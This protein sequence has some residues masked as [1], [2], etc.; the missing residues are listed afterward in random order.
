MILH[1]NLEKIGSL[2]SSINITVKIIS[3]VS[4]PRAVPHPDGRGPGRGAGGLGPEE[5]P[6]P[7]HAPLR[8][9]GEDSTLNS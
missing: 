1:L 6:A 2:S 7:R 3:I 5:H 4:P 9:Q 8:R